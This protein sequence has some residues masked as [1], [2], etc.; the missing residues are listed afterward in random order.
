MTVA[1]ARMIGGNNFDRVKDDFYPSPDEI[2]IA[3]FDNWRP[4][5]GDVWEPACGNG[6]MCEVIKRHG[7]RI[8]ASDL[9][10]RG[11]GETG[12]D[13]LME[14][15]RRAP[16]LITNPP[17]NLSHDFIAHALD[18][19]SVKQMALYLKSTY[20]HAA[21]RIDL[22]EKYPPSIIMPLTW[23]VDFTDGGQATL[24]TMW[25]IWDDQHEGET[26]YRPIRRPV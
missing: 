18:P 11:Y 26:V 12:I 21:K 16:C 23:R 7:F 15:E 25:C 17:F 5:F 14:Y 20:W 9:V 19:L 13:F 2:T 8:H 10:D 22:F 6:A 3:L 4:R 1:A 24:D